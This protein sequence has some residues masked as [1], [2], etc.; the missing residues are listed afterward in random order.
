MLFM[1]A[2][3]FF[4]VDPPVGRVCFAEVCTTRRQFLV[5][6]R[7]IRSHVRQN[8]RRSLIQP[9]LWRDVATLGCRDAAPFDREV[10]L[11]DKRSTIGIILCKQKSKTLVS[12]IRPDFDDLPG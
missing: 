7:A 3:W 10:K 5:F 1:S 6:L 8:V 9:T 12:S 2:S 4:V 11:A